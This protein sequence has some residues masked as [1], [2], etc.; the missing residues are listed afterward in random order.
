M[1]KMR[2]SK[3]GLVVGLL[4]ERYEINDYRLNKPVCH[5]KIEN[6]V[7]S[8][9]MLIQDID[10]VSIKGK[11]LQYFSPNNI[12]ILLSICSSHTEKA[13]T[14]FKETIET[15]DSNSKND[16]KEHLNSVSSIVCDYIEKIQIAIVFGYSSLETFAN[17]SIPDGYE[18]KKRNKSKGIHELYGKD[19]IERWLSLKEKFKYILSYVYKTK[20]VENQKWWG[21]FSNLEKLR[22]DIIHQK[23]VKS[24]E[25][26]KCYFKESIFNICGCPKEVLKFFCNAH[27][28]NNQTNPIWPWLVN[29]KNVFPLNQEYD[30]QRFE[31]I[32]NIHEGITKKSM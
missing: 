28:K 2:K 5:Q 1:S 18:Y 4:P 29:E 8:G 6:G 17:L 25:F 23:T 14:L 3:T 15:L 13:A 10:E 12:G 24:T 21:H 31:V 22:N 16:K 32:G 26:Y 30:P 11:K 27:A 9:S 19:S 7:I 20:K